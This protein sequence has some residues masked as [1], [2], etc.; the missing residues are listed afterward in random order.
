MQESLLLKSVSFCPLFLLLAVVVGCSGR[1]AAVPLPDLDVS[2]ASKMAIAD[3]DKDGDGELSKAELA[4]YPALAGALGEW[5]ADSN[6]KL[7]AEEI[8]TQLQ[9]WRDQGA[10]IRT[11]RCTVTMNGR[12][13]EGANVEFVPE[14]FMGEGIKTASGVTGQNG[15]VLPALSKEYLPKDLPS[16]RGMHLGIYKVRVTHPEQSIPA[17][18]NT[19]TTLGAIVGPNTLGVVLA[20]K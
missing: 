5:D 16:F 8:Q 18:F 10:A 9:K 11:V 1:P 12:G 2:V 3:A 6:R 19:D 7:S 4:K 14:P 17:E 13:L 20:V 15:L